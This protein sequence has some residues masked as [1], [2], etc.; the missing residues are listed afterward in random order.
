M[1]KKTDKASTFMGLEV[2]WWR[3][4]KESKLISKQNNHS[5]QLTVKENNSVGALRTGKSSPLRTKRI[6]PR[7]ALST[8]TLP[9]AA[10][11]VPQAPCSLCTAPTRVIQSVL[12]L[13]IWWWREGGMDRQK[14]S[15]RLPAGSYWL[16][17]LPGTD[18]PLN[19]LCP[20][21]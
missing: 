2:Q 13:S 12:L 19:W 17:T 18:P 15:H 1:K 21:M 10:R 8:L 3:D 16:Q 20:F 7:I 5:K 11:P 4:D 6:T 9:E 14:A